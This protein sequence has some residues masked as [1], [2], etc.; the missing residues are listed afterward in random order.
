[1]LKFLKS[2]AYIGT[3]MAATTA[4]A[5]TTVTF[6]SEADLK[7]ALEPLSLEEVVCRIDTATA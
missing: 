7:K 2:L 6:Q 5:T 4:S 1:M 3:I